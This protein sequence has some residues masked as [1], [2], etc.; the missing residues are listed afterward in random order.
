[1]PLRYSVPF[2]TKL[3]IETAS[4]ARDGIGERNDRSGVQHGLNLPSLI[5]TLLSVPDTDVEFIDNLCRNTLGFVCRLE[6]GCDCYRV[7][8]GVHQVDEK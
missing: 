5:V 2:P 4:V 3:A 6:I 8:V 7:L 1:M